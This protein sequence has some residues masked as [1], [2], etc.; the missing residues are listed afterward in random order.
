MACED[1]WCG[2]KELEAAG[3]TFTTTCGPGELDVIVKAYE[4]G[5]INR[6]T[7]IRSLQAL[8]RVQSAQKE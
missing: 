3:K 6:D 8:T 2:R 4:E 5:E 7:L 1:C